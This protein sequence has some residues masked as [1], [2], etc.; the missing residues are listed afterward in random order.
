[1]VSALRLA[2]EIGFEG[3]NQEARMVGRHLVQP[4]EV[5]TIEGQQYAAVG[6][7]KGQHLFIGYGAT[8]V[9]RFGAGQDIVAES[10]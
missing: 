9:A 3:T 10:S 4:D 6:N 8:G 7:R 5:P 2:G 1:M